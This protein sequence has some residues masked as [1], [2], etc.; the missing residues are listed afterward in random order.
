MPVTPKET[1][2]REIVDAVRNDASGKTHFNTVFGE[3]QVTTLDD[4]VIMNVVYGKVFAKLEETVANGGTITASGSMLIGQTSTATDGSAIVETHQAVKYRPG[5]EFF[6]KFT[7]LFTTGVTGANQFVGPFS[8]TDGFNV[9][10]V[11]ADFMVCRRSGGSDNVTTQANFSEDRLDGTGRSRFFLDPTKL[12]IYRITFGWLGIAPIYFQVMGAD[13]EWI[14][15]H[16]I[17]LVNKQTTPHIEVPYLPVRLE[18]TKT[19]GATN[20]TAK[21]GSWNA[22]TAGNKTNVA[23]R[24]HAVE[25]TDATIS[26]GTETQL[27]SLRGKTTVNSITNRIRSQLLMITVASDGAKTVSFR[28]YKDGTLTGGSWTDHDTDSVVEE[29]TTNTISGGHLQ[30]PFEV[31]KVDSDKVFVQQLDIDFHRSESI[32]ITAE[33]SN[34]SDVSIGIIWREE[35]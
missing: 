30:I 29:N 5:H 8:D 22:G 13:G 16:M 35:F 7:A 19:S 23:S 28:V 26:A 11:G 10:Y 15:F 31:A 4:E 3:K 21:S 17:D 18:V 9:G 25:V 14:T 2:Y 6:A 24:I 32:T 27:I 33:S 1:R 20:I 34:A 12:N